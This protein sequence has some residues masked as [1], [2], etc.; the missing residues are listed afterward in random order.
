M[1]TGPGQGVK[2]GTVIMYPLLRGRGSETFWE[3]CV[4]MYICP[5]HWYVAAIFCVQGVRGSENWGFGDAP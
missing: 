1:Y 2:G 3:I 4:H 5:V